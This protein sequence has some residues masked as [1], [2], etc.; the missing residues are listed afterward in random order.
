MLGGSKRLYAHKE[1]QDPLLFFWSEISLL[2]QS[3]TVALQAV[4]PG[5]SSNS[6]RKTSYVGAELPGAA[7]AVS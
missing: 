3:A 2:V 6:S 5:T 1:L 4:L 7:G